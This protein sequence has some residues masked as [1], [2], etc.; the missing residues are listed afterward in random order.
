MKLSRSSIL[1]TLL[2]LLAGLGLGLFY[3]W[4]IS[5]VTYVDADPSI[6]RADFKDQYRVVIAAAYESTHD[7]PRARARLEL[8]KDPDPVGELSAQAQRMLAGGESNQNAQPLAQL[9]ADLE[10]GYA[11][12]AQPT[13]TITKISFVGT[14]F[15]PLANTRNLSQPLR[16]P[17]SRPQ[18]AS[19]Y[20]LRLSIRVPSAIRI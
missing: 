14:P 19:T 7:L 20:L 11:S 5:P 8:L 18:R 16:D 13:A 12:L 3:S 10:Q 9:A 4:R 2:G 1:S 6:L 15:T 17:R